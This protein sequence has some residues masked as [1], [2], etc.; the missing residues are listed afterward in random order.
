MQSPI[1][2][3]EEEI[4]P[5]LQRD[6]EISYSFLDTYVKIQKRN[7]E[8]II[9][10][11]NNPGLINIRQDN[12]YV[13]YIPKFISFR[14]PGEHIVLGKRSI[15]ELLIHCKEIHPDKVRF[16]INKEKKNFEWI[17]YHYTIGDR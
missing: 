3:V 6:L 16:N 10:F 8:S 11:M 12:T 5:T 13:M 14:F 9:K 2:I 4:A 7:G 15:G 1:K 17:N